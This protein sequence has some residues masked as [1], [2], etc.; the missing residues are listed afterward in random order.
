MQ[1][2]GAR[3]KIISLP[4]IF[5]AS[6]YIILPSY[7]AFELSSFLP[8]F[9][10]SRII[11]IIMA[12]YMAFVLKKV[13]IPKVRTYT[14]IC[15]YILL[16]A[17]INVLHF[18][19]SSSYAIKEILSLFIENLLLVWLICTFIKTR[20]SLNKFIEV[21]V[22]TS[23]II[24]VIGLIEFLTGYNVFEV[25]ATTTREVVISNYERLG[26]RRTAS[27][28]GHAVYYAVYSSCM[29]PFSVYLYEKTRKRKYM[30]CL[31]L[32]ILGV[33]TSGTRGQFLPCII[34]FVFVFF[35]IDK[36]IR[37]KYRKAFLVSIIGF[38]VVSMGVPGL[39]NFI[40]ENIKS[41][42]FAL[43]FDVSVSTS[44]GVN[45][46]G[47]YSRMVQF[48]GISWLRKNGN[49]LIGFGPSPA[50]RGLVSYNFL[51]RGWLR[52]GTIDIGYV[53]WILSYGILGACANMILLVGTVIIC[54]SRLKH[55]KDK[56]IYFAFVCFFIIYFLSLLTSTGVGKVLWVVLSLI[57]ATESIVRREG[58]TDEA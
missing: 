46:S 3:K 56:S 28:F 23:A 16:I 26:M 53:G 14:L 21:M 20:E 39:R 7:F 19:D 27:S 54:I 1:I 43:G 34:Y 55:T 32:N 29:M 9:S 51:S 44:F 10:G 6:L 4:L 58:I 35:R 47:L 50:Y 8:S 41:L 31:G 40:V 13:R 22:I 2:Y 11:L 37:K 33:L 48:S 42:L 15:I 45:S 49:L 24:S 17:F 25:L 5:L 12:M 18:R 30:G 52:S 38:A 57:T 36:E